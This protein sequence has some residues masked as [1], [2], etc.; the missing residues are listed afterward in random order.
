MFDWSNYQNVSEFKLE[1]C[2]D[3]FCIKSN[4]IYM[5][6]PVINPYFLDQP[7]AILIVNAQLP[8]GVEPD[9]IL[10]KHSYTSMILCVRAAK[11]LVRL[12]GCIY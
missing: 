9:K 11:D 6:Q 7:S 4:Y 5:C 10:L 2:P 1:G 3:A 8:S 12:H